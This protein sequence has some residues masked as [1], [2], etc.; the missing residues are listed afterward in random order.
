MKHLLYPFRV[1]SFACILREVCPLL[2]PFAPVTPFTTSAQCVPPLA[3]RPR[4]RPMPAADDDRRRHESVEYL[5]RIMH[6]NQQ[7]GGRSTPGISRQFVGAAVDLRPADASCILDYFRSP[8]GS[9]I[10]WKSR[11]RRV[12]RMR[13]PMP[14]NGTPTEYCS[15]A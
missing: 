11:R 14:S 1:S 9:L 5:P 7:H 12:Q 13:R 10:T 3:R 15:A 8:P 2:N 6:R 4:G